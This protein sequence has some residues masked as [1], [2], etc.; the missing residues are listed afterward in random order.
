MSVICTINTPANPAPNA[1][2][3]WSTDPMTLET[4]FE[5]FDQFA[6]APDAV[7]DTLAPLPGCVPWTRSHPVVSLRST[8]GYRLKS[9][10][11][12]F[13]RRRFD[14]P[15][16]VRSRFVR[17]R[18]VRSRFVRSRFVRSRFVRSRFVRSRFVRSSDA[19]GIPACSRWSSPRMRATPPV[20]RPPVFR[21]PAGVPAMHNS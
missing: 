15:Q 7:A 2:S 18:F 3:A 16:F 13:V 19:G 11:D 10:R 12:K 4:F 14:C 9:L 8:T 6:D 20:P 21:T 17:S 1:T 5:K